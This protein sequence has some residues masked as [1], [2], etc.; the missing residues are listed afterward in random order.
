MSHLQVFKLSVINPSLPAIALFVSSL[1]LRYY[2]HHYYYIFL[3]LHSPIIGSI[4]YKTSCTMG[5]LFRNLLPRAP[6]EVTPLLVILG[7]ACTGAIVMSVRK[8]RNDRNLRLHPT[9]QYTLRGDSPR[10]SK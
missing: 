8:L 9:G 5:P 10:P 7:G 3:L 4:N 6:V 2:Y 1:S